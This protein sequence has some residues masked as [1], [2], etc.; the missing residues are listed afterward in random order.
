MRI[1]KPEIDLSSIIPCVL[2]SEDLSGLPLQYHLR[3]QPSFP[4]TSELT[5][6]FDVR[7][8]LGED[9]VKRLVDFAVIHGRPPR[10]S[11]SSCAIPREFDPRKFDPRRCGS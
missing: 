10:C 5:N 1:R 8:L 7:S 4:A 11:R 3:L 2:F 9:G 6:L